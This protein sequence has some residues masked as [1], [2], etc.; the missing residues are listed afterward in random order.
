MKLNAKLYGIAFGVLMGGLIT[1]CSNELNAPDFNKANLGQVRLVKAPEVDAWSGDEVFDNNA[2]G[3]RAGENLI[4]GSTNDTY[5]YNWPAEINI[6]E[7][8]QIPSE[9]QI[10]MDDWNTSYDNS[11]PI[12]IPAGQ[13]RTFQV[14]LHYKGDIYVAGTYSPG[15]LGNNDGNTIYVL[16]EGILNVE[17]VST[18]GNV[19]YN[20][21]TVNITCDFDG[22]KIGNIYT[23]GVLNISNKY[24]GFPSL[25]AGVGIYNKGGVV[26]FSTNGGE[27]SVT[28]IMGTIIS[29]NIV[30]SNGKIKFQN[31]TG[32]RDICWLQSD[33]L[34]EI[35]DGTNI[36]GEITAPNLKF[37]GAK[38]KLHP[39]GLVDIANTVD[40][41][42]SGCAILPYE[43]SEG[44]VKCQQLNV[45]KT[46]EQPS[47]IFPEGIYF[48]V[49]ENN[50]SYD[51]DNNNGLSYI[52]DR[53]NTTLDIHPACGSEG[54]TDDCEFGCGHEPHEP[55]KC[56]ECDCG[57]CPDC[58]DPEH[59]NGPCPEDECANPEVCQ[60][61]GSGDPDTP[62]TP[63]IAEHNNEVEINF[64][65]N[66]NHRGKGGKYVEED[67]V[68]K[69]SIHV[70]YPHDVQVRIPVSKKFFVDKDD[71]AILEKHVEEYW[72]WGTK[73]AAEYVINGYKVTLTVEFNED[74][75][76]VSTHGI[77]EAVM[78]YCFSTNNDGL[79][80][81]IWNYFQ[82]TIDFTMEEKEFKN[83]LK[84]ERESLQEM[85]NRSEVIFG[86]GTKTPF[87]AFTLK[88]DCP[89]YY[90]N[91]FFGKSENYVEEGGT[92]CTVSVNEDQIRFYPSVKDGQSH[93][94]GTEDNTIYTKDGASS[95]VDNFQKAE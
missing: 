14:P 49:S 67:Y 55:G 1:S 57:K 18:Q 9:C 94:N 32:F 35:T 62:D 60:P 82:S 52:K 29:D 75:I 43:G 44:L 13:T 47:S 41:T 73:N 80:F 83:A 70:R 26:E 23:N 90:I 88:D 31:G 50:I 8:M 59:P 58:G 16:P 69:L 53:I 21:G 37:D 64:S 5:D 65:I 36:F 56:P 12:L 74:E 86:D 93:L 51:P 48:N 63:V 45:L 17:G 11:K 24:A 61:K 33:G 78:E 38:I 85:L 79:N 89:D 27:W 30:K 95:H 87:V 76:I 2:F 10:F 15:T 25:P 68:T 71:L 84:D 39:N 40:I 46:G 3:T 20:A 77:N 19:I 22:T 72:Q 54:G 6:L 34:V 81:E 4:T 28:D 42:N 66:D 7:N 91:A 92:D